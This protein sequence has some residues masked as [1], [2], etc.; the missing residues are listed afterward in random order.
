MIGYKTFLKDGIIWRKHHGSL[1]PLTMPHVNIQLNKL[2][3]I[4]LL[5]KSRSILI[6]W[7]ENFGKVENTDWW[8]IIK[9][10]EENL[11]DFSGNTR[12]QI[13]KGWK[14]YAAILT[15]RKDII[16]N[17]YNVY[18]SSFKRYKTS[19]PIFTKT[20]FQE[21]IKRLPEFTEFW[22]VYEIDNN[23]IVGFS[24]NI[25]L[26]DACFYN[27]IWL[28]NDSIKK[29]SGYVLIHEMNKYYLNKNRLKYISDG[30]RSIKHDTNIHNYLIDKFKFKKIYS[31][32][33]LV[34]L[35]PIGSIISILY[36]LKG[37]IKFLP[38]SISSRISILLKQE[39]I[40]RA[41]LSNAP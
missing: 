15:T 36:N 10:K 41:S 17:A 21:M 23:S 19:E 26:N 37:L 29:Y 28:N 6:R 39:Q 27:N 8:H 13:R 38:S 9:D 24:E 33:N 30:T 7:E 40:R 31:K 11:E 25:I 18:K 4:K 14:N 5:L 34:Y 20:H 32:L 16:D 3:A 2:T 35:P 1:V 22:K 12:N